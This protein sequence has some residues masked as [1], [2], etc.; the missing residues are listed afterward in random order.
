M[1]SRPGNSAAGKPSAGGRPGLILVDDDPLIV[2]SLSFVLG[3]EFDVH[4]ADTRA[5]TKRLLQRLPQVPALALID[6]GLPPDPHAPD[7]GFALISELLA[8]NRSMKILVLSGQSDRSNIQHALTLGAVDFVP[9]PCDADLL[10]ARL[11]HQLLI[12]DAERNEGRPHAIGDNPLLGDSAAMQALRDSVTQFANTPFPVLIEGESGCGKELVAQCLH[13]ESERAG[14]PLLTVNCAAFTADLLEAQLFGHVKGAY[15][16]AEQTRTGFFED[17]NTGTLFLDE[18]GEMPLELQTK[19]LRVLENGEYYPLGETRPRHSGAR[20]IA[21]TNRDLREA[22]RTGAFRADLFHRLSV[23]S[24]SVP[25]LRSRGNDWRQLLAHFQQL[26]AG[27]IKAFEL[28][29]D[30]ARLLDKYSFP[31]NVRELR[32]IV[33]RIGARS[34]DG[35]IGVAELQAELEPGF[36]APEPVPADGEAEDVAPITT[37]LAQPGFH[38]DDEV[39]ALERRYIRAALAQCGGNLSKA[40]RLLGV[41]RTT[42]YSKVSRLGLDADGDA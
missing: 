6:L 7:E 4:T 36:T 27:T 30:A 26:Y 37:R 38:L 41:N 10:R 2:E 3:I 21:A 18:V 15:T 33:I 19:F 20:I 34:P 9:K 24:L 31:G 25:P 39:A 14:E 35:R 22:V 40:A 13:R 11:N 5:A 29:D 23:L 8:F 32:N 28:S 1:A 16:G 12:L 17:A 42:L